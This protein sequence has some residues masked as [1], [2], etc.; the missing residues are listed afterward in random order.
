[1]ILET[2][3]QMYLSFL[4]GIKKYG[5][6]VVD[7]KAFNR[8]INDWGQDEWIKN[9]IA[10]G[11]E[12]T[13]DLQDRLSVLKVITDDVYSYSKRID[14][15]SKVVI[16]SIPP[17][18]DIQAFVS[19]TGV[20]GNP[21]PAVDYY[22]PYSLKGS[23]EIGANYYPEYMTLLSVQFKIEYVDNECEKGI[24]DWLD[25]NILRTD[26]KSVIKK[27]PFRKPKDNRLY[28]E[29]VNDSFILTTGT[30]S[31]GHKMKLDYLRYPRR[32]FFSTDNGGDLY[33]EQD[34]IPNYS[35]SNNTPIGSV[36]CELP[37]S[38]RQEIVSTAVRVFIERIQDPRYKSFLNE[39]NIRI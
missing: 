11:I 1:M 24:S 7:P 39:L 5:T 22:F 21:L 16:G 34:G 29:I 2:T 30:A 28:Y 35:L 13:Q 12:L 33:M 9:N 10:K 37:N 38:L 15:A 18:K 6:G 3:Y 14:G 19:P 8:I 4:D 32:I 31:K 25:A 20:T 23:M 17:N 27:N 26:N 36:N